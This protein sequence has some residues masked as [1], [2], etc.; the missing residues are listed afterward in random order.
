MWDNSQYKTDAMA[1][2]LYV[3]ANYFHENCRQLVNL[4]FCNRNLQIQTVDSDL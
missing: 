2:D 3:K 1:Y 4:L